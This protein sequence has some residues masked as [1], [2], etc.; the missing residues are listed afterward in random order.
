MSEKEKVLTP[1]EQSKVLIEAMKLEMAGLME[2]TRAE[3]AKIIAEA[4]AEAEDIRGFGGVNPTANLSASDAA[5]AAYDNELVEIELFYDG[6]KYKDDVTVAVNGKLWVIKRGSKV[7]VP[8]FVKEALDNSKFQD[9][10][11]ARYSERMQA[12]AQARFKE[13]G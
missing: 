11:A 2:E 7:Q 3:A 6:D 1:E 4:K 13:L 10:E 5:A 12:A 9:R 8:R